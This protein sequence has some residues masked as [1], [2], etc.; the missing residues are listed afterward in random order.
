MSTRV[1]SIQVVAHLAHCRRERV[2]GDVFAG[3]G[4]GAGGVPLQSLVVLEGDKKAHRRPATRQR[5]TNG[6]WIQTG[7]PA[8]AHQ[9]EGYNLSVA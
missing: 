3:R 4:R 2:A 7:R 8:L 9:T 6:T 1:F 5:T